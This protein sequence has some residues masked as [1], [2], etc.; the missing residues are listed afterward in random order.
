MFKRKNLFLFISLFSWG[1]LVNCATLP[2]NH[3]ALAEKVDI[4]DKNIVSIVV[5]HLTDPKEIAAFNAGIF[6]AVGS[7]KIVPTVPDAIK[8]LLGS[9]FSDAT[10]GSLTDAKMSGLIALAAK[11]VDPDYVF[12]ISTQPTTI[13]NK[14]LFIQKAVPGIEVNVLLWDVKNTKLIG[15]AKY[16]GTLPDNPQIRLGSLT[17]SGKNAVNY[18]LEQ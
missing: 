17:N 10:S 18:L 3:K 4:K 9:I 16:Y 12:L 6:S 11:I 14:I 15:V 5:P 1:I 2:Q 8:N 7:E 13:L